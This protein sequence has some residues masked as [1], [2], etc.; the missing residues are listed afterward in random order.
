MNGEEGEILQNLHHNNRSH[1]HCAT[2]I[3]TTL[4]IT[5]FLFSFPFCVPFC[6]CILLSQYSFLICSSVLRCPDI[7]PNNYAQFTQ[8]SFPSLMARCF[9]LVTFFAQ[10]FKLFPYGNFRIHRAFVTTRLF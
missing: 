7:V 1:F 8:F 10:I 9:F 2:A 5:Y 4:R 3:I 6:H